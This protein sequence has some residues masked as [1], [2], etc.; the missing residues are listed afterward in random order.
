MAKIA[1]LKETEEASKAVDSELFHRVR[2]G[3][4]LSALWIRKIRVVREFFGGFQKFMKKWNMK[5]SPYKYLST[6]ASNALV[7]NCSLNCG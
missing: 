3:R 7:E 1:R 2:I 6:E 5:I 4:T